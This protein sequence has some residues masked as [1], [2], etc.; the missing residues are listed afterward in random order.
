M[1]DEGSAATG[2]LRG[3]EEDRPGEAGAPGEAGSVDGVSGAG[4][5]GGHPLP[6]EEGQ[7]EP[8]GA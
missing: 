3:I 6:S 2:G 1:T 5:P 7:G 8:Q 4:D